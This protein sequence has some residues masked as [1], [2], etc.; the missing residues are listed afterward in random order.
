M[1]SSA[2]IWVGT[3]GGGLNVT[4]P[5]SGIFKHIRHDNLKPES[6]S[7]DTITDVFIS[8][9]EVVWIATNKGLNK[10]D[11]KT[12]E[13]KTFRHNKEDPYS[14][15]SDDLTSVFQDRYGKI[16]VGTRGKG[17]NVY[18]PG[19][20]HFYLYSSSGIGLNSLSSDSINSISQGRSGMFW[21][22]TTNGGLN[23]FN[24]KSLNFKVLSPFGKK[25]QFNAS[26]GFVAELDSGDLL[27][28]VNQEGVYRF[29]RGA[30]DIVKIDEDPLITSFN[31]VIK[32]NDFSVISTTDGLYSYVPSSGKLSLMM[33]IPY[34]HTA[35]RGR[36]GKLWIG[37]DEGLLYTYDIAQKE[38][39]KVQLPTLSSRIT[40]L[41]M[42]HKGKIWIGTYG[43]GCLVLDPLSGSIT[44]YTNNS[45]DLHSVGSNFINA[46][47][48][49]SLH[50][51]W[52]STWGGGL[53]VFDPGKNNFVCLT[54]QDGLPGNSV[55]SIIV[56][57]FQNIWLGTESGI[58]KLKFHDKRLQQC[59]I[60]DLLDGLPSI[61]FYSSTF[62]SGP[63]GR[64]YLNS[65]AG[66][67]VF[68]ADSLKNNPYKPPVVI[69]DFQIFNHSVLPGDSTGILSSSI[70]VTKEICLTYK[71]NVFSF[72]FTAISFI[73][74]LKNR[75]A[76]KMEGFNNDWIYTDASK[77]YATYTNLP[78][79]SY[80]FRVKA[81]NNDGTWN[82]EGAAIKINILPPFYQT[83]WFRLLLLLTISGILY[84][85]YRIRINRIIELERIRSRISR[86]LHD[87]IGSTLSSINLLAASAQRRMD[88]KDE[89]RL[90]E[91]LAKIGGRAQRMLDNMSD[92]I[93]SIKPE[94][95]TMDKVVIRMR[96]YAST[97]FEA[98][99]INF[100]FDAPQEFGDITIPVDIKNNFYLIFKEALNNLSK[101]ADAS[102]VYICFTVR[103][104]VLL[105]EVKDN[106]K[107]FDQSSIIPG[108]GLFNIKRRAE[109]IKAQL[110][111]VSVPGKGTT[112]LLTCAIP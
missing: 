22:A 12:G 8:K 71:Q 23:A 110:Q 79:G 96:E 93:W 31:G 70:S 102:E 78:P 88:D 66:I 81:S 98:K 101:Y 40:S 56:D 32:M 68:S 13:I 37:T 83:W 26:I 15:N 92:I 85:I 74:A 30:S 50:Q 55:G 87:D 95:D 35:I 60:Y 52:I 59:R 61:D 21:A 41:Y 108:N 97:L 33:Q 19:T 6:I 47:C 25:A 65:E 29:S 106:G 64:F 58:C 17:L 39:M 94:N 20:N 18:Y 1:Y 51:M 63:S 7:S 80:I 11:L 45:R 67:V 103:N 5:A 27:V 105:L 46:I 43:D 49:D 9:D 104:K 75:Y 99:N 77:R 28:G 107:G 48:E 73:N 69:T 62:S 24:P 4:D 57:R 54:T 42:D 84:L 72:E 3:L 38:L 2:R 86:D 44:T 14:I 16:W 100:R 90:S 53:N 111:I 89:A 82:E 76:Y 112:I 34:L 91:A 10:F 36:G 109:D